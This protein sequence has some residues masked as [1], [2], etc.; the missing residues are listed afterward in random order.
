MRKLAAISI[1]FS[2]A[3][4]ASCYFLPGRLL[5]PGA[6]AGLVIFFLCLRGKSAGKTYIRFGALGIALGLLLSFAQLKLVKEPAGSLSGSE[7]TATVIVTE[8]PQVFDD[9]TSVCVRLAG[10][11]A[12]KTSARI[13]DYDGYLP[14]LSPGDEVTLPLRFTSALVRYGEQTD[15]FTSRNVFAVAYT[16]GEVQ[17]TSGGGRF[18]YFPQYAAQAV[19]AAVE[20]A[21]PAGQAPF[22]KALLMGD[23]TDFYSDGSLYTAMRGSGLIHVVAVSGLHVSFLVG[24]LQLLMGRSR[25]SSILCIA[26]VWFF[27]IMTGAGPSTL[28]AGFMQTMV[29][30]APIL[31]RRSDGLTSLS[32]ALM[33]ILA[34]NPSAAGSAALQ[35]SFAAMAGILFISPAIYDRLSFNRP[36]LLPGRVGAYLA[37]V[38]SSSV[39]ATVFTAP[40]LALRFGYVPLLGIAANVLCLWAVTLCFCGGFIACGLWA[41]F[42][43]AG[44]VLGMPV[45]LLVKYISAA[46]KLIASV[47][48]SNVYVS[49]GFLAAWLV[50]TYVL[51]IASYLTKRGRLRF[52]IP[53]ALSAITLCAVML[54]TSAVYSFGPGYFC[55][56]NVGQGQSL[57]LMSGRSTVVIDCGGMGSFNNA[58]ESTAEFL[59][60]RGRLRVDA[61][62]LTH[63]HAD[64]ANGVARLMDMIPVDT[65]VLA[66]D[67][68]DSD[69]LLDEILR[70]AEEKGTEIVYISE[71]T[72][73]TAGGIALSIFV[74]V[75]SGGENERCL[76]MVATM[77][78]CDALITG[79]MGRTAERELIKTH[80]VSGMEI[81]VAGHHGS[82]GA[83]SYELLAESGAK[84][85]IFSVGYNTYGHPSAQ[86]FRRMEAVG[87]ENYYRTDMNGSIT[88]SAGE[89]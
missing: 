79:D 49:N 89:N 24:L 39:G 6:I 48:Y 50:F 37:G 84:T 83:C 21:L 67:V 15:Y 27:V 56:V 44:R 85:A 73:Y 9:Y 3:V 28:R 86:V 68:E 7:L 12:V 5:L 4:F 19:K 71:D 74:P 38:F 31:F 26:L 55:A 16:N 57:A 43:A 22:M 18:L 62:V 52:V 54:V 77:G 17:K 75:S 88:I 87:V 51:F 47:P 61:V 13:Y 46:V 72:S 76:S 70:K 23:K 32:F 69:G 36:K 42:P 60:G 14:P 64:H 78:E 20:G 2:G 10:D 66:R 53:T 40:I 33:V 8:F 63:L 65:L 58:G 1:A 45:A 80:D 35:L 82:K 59:L 29:L 81:I 25:R 11:N 30:I 34:I 41:V